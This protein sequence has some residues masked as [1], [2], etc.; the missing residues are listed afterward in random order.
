MDGQVLEH[1]MMCWSESVSDETHVDDALKGKSKAIPGVGQGCALDH[2]SLK[3]S[4]RHARSFSRSVCKA[5]HQP[6]SG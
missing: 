2:L 5:I 6:L 3:L 1:T 4:V